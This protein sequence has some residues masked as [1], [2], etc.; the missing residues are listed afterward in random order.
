VESSGF[1]A[2][3]DAIQ[4]KKLQISSAAIKL[5]FNLVSFHDFFMTPI[6]EGHNSFYL[7][8]KEAIFL[9]PFFIFIDSLFLMSM[10]FSFFRNTM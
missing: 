4:I 9:V 7:Q 8:V 3:D 10:T 6:S 2:H 1:P 5:F